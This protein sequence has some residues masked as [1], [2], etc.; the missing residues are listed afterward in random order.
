ML[1]QSTIVAAALLATTVSAQV[2]A[3]STIDP[4][5]VDPTLRSTMPSAE[6]SHRRD[7]D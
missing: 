7:E 6:E 5:T 1:F 2:G 3:N 4:N